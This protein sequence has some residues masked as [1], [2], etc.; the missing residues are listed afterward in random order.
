MS[1]RSHSPADRRLYR[2]AEVAK[3]LHCSEWW[4]KEQARKRRIPFAWIGGSY[5]F[6]DDHV[7]E[8]IRVFEVRPA[9]GGG[10]TAAASSV[11][12]QRSP[13]TAAAAVRLRARAP[14]R[15]LRGGE[16]SGTAA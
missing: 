3:A 5:R 9:A 6:T 14:R 16:G 12:K 2:P 10:S 13:R 1:A 11:R 15:S 8:I 7:A 4:I